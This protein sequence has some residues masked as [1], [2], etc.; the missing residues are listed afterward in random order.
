MSPEE[1][2]ALHWEAVINLARRLDEIAGS[3]EIFVGR[4]IRPADLQRAAR[5]P[6]QP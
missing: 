2:G 1:R 5:L 6:S 3:D 4:I